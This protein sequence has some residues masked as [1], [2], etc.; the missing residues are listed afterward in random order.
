M[1][2]FQEVFFWHLVYFIHIRIVSLNRHLCGEKNNLK[3]ISKK[4]F[5]IPYT[6]ND[7]AFENNAIESRKLLKMPGASSNDMVKYGKNSDERIRDLIHIY[8]KIRESVEIM[9]DSASFGT[10]M[11]MLSC[12]LHLV[13]TPYFLL[14]EIFKQNP[15]FV[16]MTLQVVWFLGHVGRLLIIVEPCQT[17]LK[18][19][20]VTHN[21]VSE[22]IL[23]D[24]NKDSKELL[25][26]FISQ[27]SCTA[28][29]F[30]ASGFFNIDRNL[31]TSV[32][33]YLH[34]F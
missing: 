14:V 11:T 3:A 24:F 32:R 12:L 34:I 19:Y 13:I 5:L 28:I 17:C 29:S 23:M 8:G 22:M 4:P 7:N 6:L 1:L 9:N 33:K 10:V 25:K 26:T 31:L 21:L 2:L 18:E 20:K 16:F 30:N 27:I 15:S